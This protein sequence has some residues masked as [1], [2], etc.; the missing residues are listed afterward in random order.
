MESPVSHGWWALGRD[1]VYFAEVGTSEA[2]GEDR[3]LQYFSFTT[4]RITTLAT[5][6]QA[7]ATNPDF[8]VSPDERR[9]VYGEL[10]SS[11][12][13]MLIEPAR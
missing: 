5:I 7:L 12:N 2:P 9:I 3:P 8:C 6:R 10:D 13:L 1:G 11:A 4:H